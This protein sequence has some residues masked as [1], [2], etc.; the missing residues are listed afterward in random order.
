MPTLG[1]VSQCRYRIH[2]YLKKA[3]GHPPVRSQETHRKLTIADVVENSLGILFCNEKCN[4]QSF[5][6][7]RQSPWE[8]KLGAAGLLSEQGL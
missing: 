6:P 8:A 4:Y 3:T 1:S 5:S 7:F 2:Y